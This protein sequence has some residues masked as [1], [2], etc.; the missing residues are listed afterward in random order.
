MAGIGRRE[1]LL[2]LIGCD[3]ATSLTDSIVGITRLQKMLF[4]LEQ[5]G[6]VHAR[7]D[8]FA[9]EPYKAGPYSSRLYDDLELLENLKLVRS[10]GTAKSTATETAELNRLNFED[11]MGGFEDREGGLPAGDSR[12]ARR[13]S[14]TPEGKNRAKKLLANNEYQP[15]VDGIRKVKSKYSHYS[16]RDLLRYVYKEYPDMT[17]ESEIIDEVLGRRR[18]H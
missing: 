1:L 10:E 5:E 18:S 15:V 4:L 7:G 11:L 3:E 2:L 12:E 14:L 8:G 16:L 17:V 9:F 13:F 6:H